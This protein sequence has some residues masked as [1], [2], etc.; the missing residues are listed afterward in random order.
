MQLIC[1]WI[2]HDMALCVCVCVC[3][4]VCVYMFICACT[5]VEQ[6]AWPQPP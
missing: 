3:V 1:I 2:K 5:S 6:L 4:F